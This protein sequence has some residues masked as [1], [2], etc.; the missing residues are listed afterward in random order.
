[1]LKIHKP[2]GSEIMEQAQSALQ[3][4]KARKADPASHAAA[5]RDLI[6]P[7]PLAFEKPSYG[8]PGY[9]LAFGLG[10]V[11]QE[12]EIA[13]RASWQARRAGARPTD[14]RTVRRPGPL[15]SF[16]IGDPDIVLGPSDPEPPP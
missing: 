16:G 7:P 12:E 11:G 5:L 3:R 10:R 1:M 8:T 9:A 4:G 2:T 15:P 13:D 14:H 6:G